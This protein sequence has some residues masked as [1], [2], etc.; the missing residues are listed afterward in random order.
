VHESG[1]GP[2][3]DIEWRVDQLLASDIFGFESAPG[4][5][6]AVRIKERIALLRRK[7]EL[8]LRIDD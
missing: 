6:A 2:E 3:R 7:G 5:K 1:S 8:R 4:P